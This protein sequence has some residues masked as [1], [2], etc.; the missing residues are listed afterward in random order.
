[1]VDQPDEWRV[2]LV[3]QFFNRAPRSASPGFI[4]YQES[5]PYHRPDVQRAR[6]SVAS[7]H[8]FD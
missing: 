4:N 6:A 3:N 8:A 7:E 2:V 1:M 5:S